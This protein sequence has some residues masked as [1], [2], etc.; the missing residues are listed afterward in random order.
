MISKAFY[1]NLYDVAEEHELDKSQV[2]YAFEQGL[3]AACKKQLGVQTCRVEFKEEKNEILIYGQYFVL[4][5][6]ELSFDLDKKY[7]FIKLSDAKELS[8]KAKPG[9]LLEI[10]IEPSEFNYNAARD[11]KNRF[12]EVLNQVI[13]ERDYQQLKDLQ[14]EMV[15]AR[16]LEVEEDFYRIEIT[17]DVTTRLPR[18]EALPDEKLYVGDRIRVYITE[19][20][21]RKK[22]IKVFVSRRHNNLVLKLLEEH[23]PEIKDGTIEI[24][25]IARDPG[26]RSKVGLRSNNPNVDPIGASVGEGGQRIKEISKFIAGEKIDLFRWSENERELIANSL[27]PS[28]VIAV[29]QVDP[30]K[31]SAIAI[32]PDDQLSLAIGKLGQ[33]VKLAVQASGWNIDIKSE[34]IAASEGIIY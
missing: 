27:Q 22:G 34:S 26:D 20:E 5:E 3:I 12:N 30:K 23:I 33:N 31:K 15:T 11:L 17:K 7:T 14:Y 13:K 1:Q 19:V 8:P 4:P 28:T 21:M 29:T 24:L 9:E 25:G 10:K 16:I 18:T 2:F 32:V 6:G